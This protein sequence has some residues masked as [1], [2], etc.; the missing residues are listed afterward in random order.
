MDGSKRGGPRPA[1]SNYT[2]T[3]TSHDDNYSADA[4]YTLFDDIVLN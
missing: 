2:L 4:S 3:L 1:G